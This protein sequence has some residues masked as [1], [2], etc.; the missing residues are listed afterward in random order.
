MLHKDE[1]LLSDLTKTIHADFTV[2]YYL[3]TTIYNHMPMMVYKYSI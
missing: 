1:R 3:I 2:M